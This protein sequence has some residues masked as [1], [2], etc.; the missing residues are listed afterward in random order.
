MLPKKFLPKKKENKMKYEGNV[1]N[2][3]KFFLKDKKNN[4]KFLLKT[5]YDWIDNN[6][7]KYIEKTLIKEPKIIELGSGC[8]FIKFFIKKKIILT[9]VKKYDWIDFTIYAEELKKLKNK[10]IDIL[11]LSHTFHHLKNIKLFFKNSERVLKKGGY[12]IIHDPELSLTFKIAILLM[13]HE[14][15]DLTTNAFHTT[16]N[17]KRT[18]PWDANLALVKIFFSSK[19]NFENKFTNLKVLEN[20]F[21]EFFIFMLSGGIVAKTFT[22]NLPKI[23]LIFF[24]YLDKLLVN[25]LPSIFAWTRRIVIK[26]IK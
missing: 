12:I 11:I 21:S 5:R 22:I 8:G 20:S 18:N 25:L 15:Y 13:K 7:N 2:A 14:G 6:I 19:K 26:K 3:R 23:F 16:K 17:Y 24:F 9:D 4:L 10:S 1:I